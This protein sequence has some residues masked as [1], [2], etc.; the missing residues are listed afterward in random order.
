MHRGEKA[1]DEIREDIILQQVMNASRFNALELH[2]GVYRPAI[3]TI[4]ETTA[5][6]GGVR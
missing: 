4:T 2:F 3:A 5:V 1:Q 6:N